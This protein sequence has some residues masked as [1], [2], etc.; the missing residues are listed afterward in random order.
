MKLTKQELGRM[1]NALYAA[2][3]REDVVY[4]V[5]VSDLC[6]AL[7]ELQ[8]AREILEEIQNTIAPR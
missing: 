4:G 6:A 1:C 5:K 2:G 7:N 3:Y 8:E